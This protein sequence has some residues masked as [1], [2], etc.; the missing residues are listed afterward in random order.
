[1]FCYTYRNHFQFGYNG[2]PFTERSSASDRF[3]VAYGRCL[4][5]PGDF[6]A[7]CLRGARLVRDS[8][9]LP[10][11]VLFSGGVESEMVVRS[12]LAAGI[13]IQVAILRFRGGLNQHDIHYALD[14]CRQ[15][16]VRPVIVDLDLLSFW[17]NELFDYAEISHSVS[18]QF[19]TTMW[20]CDQVDGVPIIG[21]GECFL[22]VESFEEESDGPKPAPRSSRW[23]LWER[24]KVASWYRFFLHSDRPGLGGF[25]QYTPELMHAF[26]VDSWTRRLVQGRVDGVLE[27][28]STKLRV[29]QKHFPLQTRNKY[30]GFEKVME[31]DRVI[32]SELL[33]L[34]GGWDQIAKSEY[35]ALVDSLAFDD[36]LSQT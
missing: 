9:E 4:R 34:Y 26:L 35:E 17:E 19:C 23:F 2:R 6:H 8:T 33:R 36:R 11:T 25:F 5:R 12:F 29:Y 32:R 10:L 28:E 16:G 1:M 24:E 27:N 20:L 13:P 18:P 15:A 14:Y 22:A 30:T 7:E 3:T 31:H 21:G